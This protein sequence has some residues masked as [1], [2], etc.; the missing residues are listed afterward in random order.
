MSKMAVYVTTY[1]NNCKNVIKNHV[2]DDSFKKIKIGSPISTCPHCN[3]IIFNKY[4]KEYDRFTK[5]DHI[6]Y[7]LDYILIAIMISAI[8]SGI[9]TTL[10]DLS[11]KS[12][13]T[14]FIFGTIVISYFGCKN[15]NKDLQLSII[16]S[17]KRLENKE[18]RE[19][20]DKIYNN[21]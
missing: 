8:I 7:Y 4:Y 12:L 10:L 19:L 18:Y 6:L 1:C 20:L 16:E 13:I 21:K 15:I 17:K 3:S 2:R 11:N 14:L 9:I 5:K